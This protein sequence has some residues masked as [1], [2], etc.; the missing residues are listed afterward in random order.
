EPLPREA[1]MV[2]AS[3]VGPAEAGAE[4]APSA[5]ASTP[6]PLATGAGP[7]AIEEV[8]HKPTRSPPEGTLTIVF[9]DIAGSS[10]LAERLGDLRWLE[11]LAAHD[12]LLRREA[13]AR[14]GYVVKAQGDGLMLAFTSARAA[15]DF[16]VAVQR[17]LAARNADVPGEELRV[18]IGLHTGEA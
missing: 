14:D 18:R 3:A 10:E 11:V 5:A 6:V 17:G 9:T 16:A 12:A 8:P 15:I 2:E 1:E 7:A 13:A 4:P